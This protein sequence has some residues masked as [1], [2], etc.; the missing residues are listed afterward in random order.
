M[1]IPSPTCSPQR[2]KRDF[3]VIPQY[4]LYISI[5]TP[6]R[7]SLLMC[8]ISSLNYEFLKGKDHVWIIFISLVHRVGPRTGKM[9][10]KYLKNEWNGLPRGYKGCWSWKAFLESA[11]P[12]SLFDWWRERIFQK[13]KRF[14]GGKV[15]SLYFQPSAHSPL[16]HYW[17]ESEIEVSTEGSRRQTDSLNIWQ[18]RQMDRHWSGTRNGTLSL[19]L[20]NKQ[21]DKGDVSTGRI[22][23]PGRD[24]GE[25]K[26]S[27][28]DS[29]LILTIESF[30]RNGGKEEPWKVGRKENKGSP[31]KSAI[32]FYKS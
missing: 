30:A 27:F 14:I 29:W 28:D 12:T 9:V 16:L 19:Q 7:N 31:G 22:F 18:C 3:F 32:R 2:L 15:R 8:L 13:E 23:A 6:H 26:D 11:T 4:F 5:N 25:F 10:S 1:Q 20:D 24:D 17:Q 21:A